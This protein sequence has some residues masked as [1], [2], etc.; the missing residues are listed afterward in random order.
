M[1]SVLLKLDDAHEKKL[2]DLAEQK[3]Q[4]K[5]GSLTRVVQD[6]LD[7]EEEA[8]Q[9]KRLRGLKKLDKFV[10]ENRGK[11]KIGYKFRRE[12]FY[13]ELDRGL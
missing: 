6:F 10:K 12:E 3:Y 9:K 2:R 4:G 7:A 11:L 8:K 5:K 13:E 1:G